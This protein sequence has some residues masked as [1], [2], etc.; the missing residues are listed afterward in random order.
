M[1]DSGWHNPGGDPPGPYGGGAPPPSSP[2]PPAPGGPG[3]PGGPPPPQPPPPGWSGVPGAP[4][5]PAAVPWQQPQ[6]GGPPPPP[7][8]RW[9]MVALFGAVVLLVVAIIGVA[10]TSGGDDDDETTTGTVDD[11]SETTEPDT[12]DTTEP[13]DDP[14]EPTDPG[15][16]VD[17]EG[18]SAISMPE[19][20]AFTAL[21][22]DLAGS[23]AEMFPDDPGKAD[24]VQTAVGT[25]PRAIIFYGVVAEEVGVNAFT[26]N[27]NIN[28]TST[29]G[30]GNLSYEEFA[31]EV[32][33]GID[34]IGA[35]VT[36]DEPF[37]LAGADGIRI[38]F[39]YDPALGASGVQYSAVID[40]EL[41]VINFAST[42]VAA[43]T[44][45]FDQIAASFELL[46]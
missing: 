7:E 32:R 22:G 19:N 33:N 42:D 5:D 46:G 16:F 45:D 2:T 44:A 38:E 29:P 4:H 30:A 21:H 8:R 36:G 11:P 41:W 37:T 26:T 9:P 40:D 39:D 14:E 12:P 3:A 34:L 1:S 20:W 23:G 15:A 10:V 31:T 25:L 18:G 28:S 13:E 35:T 27:V 43:H 6:Y 17:D 24:L